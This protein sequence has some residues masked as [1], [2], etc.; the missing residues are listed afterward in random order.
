MKMLQD[1]SALF[2][3]H[4][5]PLLVF[6]GPTL[7]ADAYGDLRLRE[8]GDLD[9]LIRPADFPRTKKMLT[10]NGF[11][12][13]ANQVEQQ[14]QNVFACEF[15]RDGIELD[16]HWDL[17][18]KWLNY[19]VDFDRLWD[20]GNPLTNRQ[21]ARKLRPEDSIELLC[22]HGSRHW[23][24]RLRWI[25]DIAEL[26]NRGS[27]TD[28]DRVESTAAGGRCRRSVWLGLWLA[29]EL[30]DAKLPQEV[31]SKLQQSRVVKQLGAQV[32]VW[33]ANAQNAAQTRTL[34]DRFLFRMRLSERLRDR[35]PQ[36]ASY[37]LALPSRSP[38]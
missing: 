17:A 22:M 10:S 25:C 32:G 2:D 29:S 34:S 27:I 9:L 30:L 24:D 3:Q 15:R 21:F 7:A 23:W 28:W 1:V 31:R 38:T 13:M 35:L 4:S 5:L 19:H 8:C 26:V 6:K 14:P 11:A 36:I 33:L 16:V 37:L 20:D 18:P 12:C